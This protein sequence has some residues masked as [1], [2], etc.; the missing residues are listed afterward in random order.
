[1]TNTDRGKRDLL[2]P[3]C[4]SKPQGSDVYLPISPSIEEELMTNFLLVYR[5]STGE[6][7]KCEDL[8]PDPADALER[9]A[10]H[11]R[12]NRGDPDI[13]VVVL[14]ATDRQALMQTHS[15]YF[16]DVG[17]LA[18]D[19]GALAESSGNRNPD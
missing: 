2:Q 1:L 11:E 4:M 14:I 16:K 13:E 5:R 10:S 8:G 9:R 19:L 6:L 18:T 3:G 7:L 15:R 17:Q 12:L